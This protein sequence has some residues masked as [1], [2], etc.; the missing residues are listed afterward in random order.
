[1]SINE[2][3]PEHLICPRRVSNCSGY[4]FG[5]NCYVMNTTPWSWA[6]VPATGLP[7]TGLAVVV[8]VAVCPMRVFILIYNFIKFCYFI[9]LL[10]KVV[11]FHFTKKVRV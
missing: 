4:I 6:G 8:K 1:M 10:K 7:T 3:R 5:V 2:K 9:Y 11:F